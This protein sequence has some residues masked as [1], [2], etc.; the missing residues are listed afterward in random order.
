MDF[1]KRKTST[2]ASLSSNETDKSPKGT[3][4]TPIIP[5]LNAL[6]NHPSYLTTS[7]CSG[8]ISIRSQPKPNP[9]SNNPAKKK[10]QGGTWI[11][12][13]H[14]T[15]DPDSVISLLFT[16]STKFTQIS[17]LVFRFEPLIIAVECRDIN[18]AQNLVSLAISCGFRESGITSVRFLAEVANEKMEANRKR[19]EGFLRAF[20]KG[21]DGALENANGSM[22]SES[23][24]CNEGQYDL[25]RSF[26]DIQDTVLSEKARFS[27]KSLA[28]TAGVHRCS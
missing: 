13:T 3:L 25:E 8:R 4:D 20:L 21:H 15:A 1:D 22:C 19:S 14:D 27:C 26:G 12:I 2:L 11:F 7:S 6:N 10:A 17:E 9:N 24:D 18:S 16:Y 23:G 28:G 5:L